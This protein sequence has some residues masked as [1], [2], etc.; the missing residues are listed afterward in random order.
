MWCQAEIAPQM[1]RLHGNPHATAVFALQTMEVGFTEHFRESAS[2]SAQFGY[3][4]TI[5]DNNRRQIP[6]SNESLEPIRC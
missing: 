1:L 2:D 6:E 3:Q 5:P 4:R